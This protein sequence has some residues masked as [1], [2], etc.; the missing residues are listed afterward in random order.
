L[1]LSKA[2]ALIR[3]FEGLVLHAYQDSVGIWTI[4][5]GTT[6]IDGRPVTAGMTC[7]REQAE[8]WME[9]EATE[10]ANKIRA[11]L[12]HPVTDNEVSA[13]IS[14]SYNIGQSALYHSSLLASINAGQPK[15]VSASHFMSWVHAGGHILPGLVT[16]RREEEAVFLS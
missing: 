15:Q 11:W 7:T 12:K 1:D 5:Y 3:K 10:C 6:H 2:F 9:G 8:S 14:L 4:G 13:M 16:R